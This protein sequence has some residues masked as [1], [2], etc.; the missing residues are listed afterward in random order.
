[1]VSKNLLTFSILV[2]LLLARAEA[3]PFEKGTQEFGLSNLGIG[4]SS[5]GGMMVSANSRYQYF[6]LNR[7]SAGGS[8]FY[9]NFN[10]HEWM[11]LGPVVS[12]IFFT[13]PSWFGRIDQ[14]LTVAK[15]NG[16][17]DKMSSFY[18]SSGVSINYLPPMTNFFI[19]GGYVNTYA[20]NDGRVMRPNAFQIF[21][22]WLWQ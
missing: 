8:I 5:S 22:G 6:L 12:Y 11:G 7:F 10:D 14:Q 2:L 1:M 21:A 16:F 9:N 4:Y 3:S 19:G 15:F 17:S 13:T 18:G 20:L